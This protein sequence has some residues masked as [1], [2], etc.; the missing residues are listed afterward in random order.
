MINIHSTLQMTSDT[1]VLTVIDPKNAAFSAVRI[2]ANA[3]PGL[4]KKVRDY[5]KGIK[6]SFN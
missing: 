6:S 3:D 4:K 5:I 2:L 1:P